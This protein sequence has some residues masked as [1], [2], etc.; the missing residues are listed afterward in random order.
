MSINCKNCKKTI[1]EDSKFCFNCG[2]KIEKDVINENDEVLKFCD[3]N[4]GFTKGQLYAYS[5]RI[6]FVSKKGIKKIYYYNLENVKKTFGTLELETIKDEY[7]AFSVEDNVDEW[8]KFIDDRMIYCKENNQNIET[9]QEKTIRIDENQKIRYAYNNIKK[10]LKEKDGKVHIIMINS[11]DRFSYEELE[12][13]DK[14]TNEVD[15]IVSSMQ[16]DGYEIITVKYQVIKGSYGLSE[17]EYYRTLIM[18]K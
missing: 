18:Y 13:A 3:A 8:V 9:E 16:D 14:Y 17:I 11:K 12:C 2:V 7:E 5:D 10:F 15:S 1:S 6:E 4:M